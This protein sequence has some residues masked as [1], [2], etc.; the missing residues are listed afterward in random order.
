MAIQFVFSD[1]YFDQTAEIYLEILH[2]LNA[3][4][5]GQNRM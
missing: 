4:K 2:I 3:Y 1:N 5:H